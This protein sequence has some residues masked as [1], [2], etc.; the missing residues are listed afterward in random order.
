M[1]A[2]LHERIARDGLDA[3][4]AVARARGLPTGDPRVLSARG[5]LVV[6]LAPAPVVARVATLSAWS[7][8]DPAAWLAREVAVA[9]AAAAAGASVLEPS[10]EPGPYLDGAHP[11]TL[12]AYADVLRQR[13]TPARAAEALAD[14]HRR[15]TL[16]LELPWLTPVHE[17]IP[18]ALDALERR[19]L[20]DAA[21]R[22]AL[23]ARFGEVSSTLD[24]AVSQGRAGPIGVLHGDAHA[25]NLVAVRAPADGLHDVATVA[26]G[27]TDQGA[28]APGGDPPDHGAGVRWCWTDFE[29]ACR[30]P[31]AWDL[32][33]LATSAGEH[34]GPRAL[35]AYAAASGTPVPDPAVLAPF[36]AARR[37]EAAVWLVSMA[38]VYPDRYARLA[39]RAVADVVAEGPLP[40]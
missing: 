40:D 14:L 28:G 22:T 29:E 5:N 9:R 30:G 26:S 25:G 4:L 37:L 20:L 10:D 11:V 6:H 13:P 7:R 17:Q 19:D 15:C 38:D 24:L 8:R 2:P 36:A 27:A 39:P 35:A 23:R 18:D 32:A 1:A 12:W 21:T 31:L 3:A 34:G 16:P 33:V